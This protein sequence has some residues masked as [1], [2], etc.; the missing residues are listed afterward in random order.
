MYIYTAKEI[1]YLQELEYV[2]LCYKERFQNIPQHQS[3]EELS[4][5]MASSWLSLYQLQGL[6]VGQFQ[7]SRQSFVDQLEVIC[8]CEHHRY[9]ISTHIQYCDYPHLHCV[10]LRALLQER[11]QYFSLVYSR[12]T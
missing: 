8:T 9:L 11:S 2:R 1:H 7:L 4:L 3:L 12:D 10:L 5:R 6:L